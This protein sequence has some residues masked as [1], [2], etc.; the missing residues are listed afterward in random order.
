MRLPMTF[1]DV[2]PEKRILNIVSRR[3]D[4]HDPAKHHWQQHGILILSSN[5]QGE[6]RISMKFNSF[7][8]AADFDGWFSAMPPKSNEN[9]PY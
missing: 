5:E 2:M 3:T 6:E 1:G 9:I 4:A 7:P 8:I